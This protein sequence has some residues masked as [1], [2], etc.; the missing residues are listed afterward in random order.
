M[1]SLCVHL[2]PV[3]VT[4]NTKVLAYCTTELITAVKSFMI[5][6]PELNRVLHSKSNAESCVVCTG[7]TPGLVSTKLITMLLKVR[8]PQLQKAYLERPDHPC[9]EAH[10]S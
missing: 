2:K 10:N 5:Q 1:E 8:M 6:A 7:L 4:N 9:N 3:K